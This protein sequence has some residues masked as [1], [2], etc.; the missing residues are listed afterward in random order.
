VL[1]R[2]ASKKLAAF[3]V[4]VPQLAG[5][6][7]FVAAASRLIDDPRAHHYWDQSD[8]T[9]LEFGRV[10]QAPGPVWDVYL[11]YAPGIRWIAQVPPRPTFWMQQLGLPNAPWLDAPALAEHVRALLSQT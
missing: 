9:G 10:L 3:V 7:S 4:W 11:L 1:S 8:V 2:I 5:R 6:R